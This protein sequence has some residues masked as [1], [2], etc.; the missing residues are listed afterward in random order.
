MRLNTLIDWAQVKHQVIEAVLRSSDNL[1]ST[2]SDYLLDW[3]L[4]Q[5]LLL[6]AFLAH[7]A[8]DHKARLLIDVGDAIV[9]VLTLHFCGA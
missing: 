8:S 2:S 4:K 5:T 7:E 3:C 1:E 9:L 6:Y